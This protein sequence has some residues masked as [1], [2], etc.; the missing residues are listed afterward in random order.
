M[1]KP[2]LPKLHLQEVTDGLVFCAVVD[3]P[4]DAEL[5]VLDNQLQNSAEALR[6]VELGILATLL[7]G[8]HS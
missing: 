7:P 8:V 4:I 3:G 2:G 5:P 1:T 6:H